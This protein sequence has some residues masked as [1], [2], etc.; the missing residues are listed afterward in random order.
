MTRLIFLGTA[1]ALPTGARG[2]VALALLGDPSEPGLLIDCGDG[3][4]RALARAEAS[5]DAI[6]D[7]FALSAAILTSST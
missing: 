5:P 3:V 2:N 6:G 1:A 4:Y 7:V